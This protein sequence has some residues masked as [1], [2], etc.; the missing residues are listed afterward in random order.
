MLEL[1]MSPPEL[2]PLGFAFLALAVLYARSILLWRARTRGLPLPP[3]PRPLP[4]IGNMLDV[5]KYKPWRGYRALCAE[6]GEMVYMHVLG[7]PMLV[8]GSP[9]LANELL[10]KRSGN[11]PDRPPNPV[12]ELSGQDL[13]TALMPY[14]QWWRRHRRSFWQHF[15]PGTINRYL[16]T[17]RVC[18][19]RFLGSILRSPASLTN[20]IR[21]S[22]QGT[23]LQIVYGTDIKDE[24]DVR[25]SVA[26]EAIEA[27]GQST[28]GHFL[29]EILPFLRHVP[30]WVPG[31]GFQRLFAKSKIANERLKHALFD[32]VQECLD[33]GEH[34]PGMATTLLT[35]MKVDYNDKSAPALEEIDIAKDVCAVAVVGSSDT[36]GNTLEA[37]C[38]AMALYPD[39]QKRAQA[40]LDAIVGPG[41][42]PDHTDTDNL[43][44]I[45][46]VVKESMRWHVVLPVGIPHR[47][48]EDDEVNGYFIPAGTTI[49]TNVWGILH[50]PDVYEDPFAFRPERYIKD[51]KL[52]TTVQDPTDFIDSVSPKRI[53]P[54]RYL[55][56]PSL[57]INIA[58]LLHVFDFSLPLDEN[59]QPVP[60]KYEEGHG[61]V[62]TPEDCRCVIK[63]RSAE[64]EAMIKEAYRLATTEDAVEGLA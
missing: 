42:L 28:P 13:N 20:N 37:F 59:G 41:R 62:S 23:I 52:D 17:Q 58:S 54:G 25:L 48:L 29:V 39:V 49:I 18:T 35:E 57:F 14:G 50:D 5:P 51:G 34:R 10:N 22:M 56:V 8:V 12:V 26:A 47:T 2:I 36:T 3:G 31:A 55:A 45:N 60:V 32:E 19:H 64:A 38:L 61:L 16:D 24:S 40:E 63:P 21:Y 46:A 44:Y 1:Y 9:Q 6:Y 30:S 43:V 27:I 33:R 11:T 53:C 4:V 7:S 15:H